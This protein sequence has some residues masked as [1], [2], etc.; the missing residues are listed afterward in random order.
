MTIDAGGQRSSAESGAQADGGPIGFIDFEASG[1][2]ARSWP[3]EVGWG[4]PDRDPDSVLIT[5]DPRWPMEAWDP[6]AQAL[7]GLTPDQLR[8][9]GVSPREA[10]RRLDAALAGRHVYSDAPDYDATWLGVL[11]QTAAMRPSFRICDMRDLIAALAP[12]D[13]LSD[14]L[15]KADRLEP[16]THRAAQ[17]VRNLQAI[18]SLSVAANDRLARAAGK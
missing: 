14:I 2:G 3:I 7:H 17:D 18:H 12:L 13:A 9:F 8:E 5:P 15:E 10:C 4:L 11:Y 6:N 1:L 16:H